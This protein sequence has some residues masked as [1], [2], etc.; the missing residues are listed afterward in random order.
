MTVIRVPGRPAAHPPPRWRRVVDAVVMD[1]RGA[2]RHVWLNW[3]AGSALTPRPVR[4][5]LYRAFG[6]RIR[7]AN[8]GRA[9]TIVGSRLAIG[10][11]TFVNQRC[12]F[13]AVAPV[14]IGADC[15]L[16]MEV[17]ILTSHH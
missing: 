8:V 15:Q 1:L 17:M 4:Y 7:S 16:G 10:P 13:E 11:R 6:L 12:F 3:C 2:W 9:C 14:T 5:S